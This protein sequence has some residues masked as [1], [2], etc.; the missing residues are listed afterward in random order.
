MSVVRGAARRRWL[1]AGAFVTVLCAT[2][3]AIAAYPARAANPGPDRLRRL[4]LAS[5]RVAHEGLAESRGSL[6][7]PALP[8]LEDAAALLGGTA[9]IRAWDDGRRSRV[10]L[11]SPTGERDHFRDGTGLAVWDYERDLLTRVAGEPVVR[12][13]R[14]GDLLPPAL[15]RRLLRQAG[16]GDR[17]TAVQSRRVA[18]RAVPGLRVTAT[19]PDTTIGAVEVWADPR[20]GLP[21]EVRLTARGAA[22]PALT[23]RFLDLRLRRPA[24]DAVAP[25]PA[26]GVPVA[27]VETPD[28]FS[29]LAARTLVPLPGRLAGRPAM[30]GTASVANVRGYA[31]GFASF[32]VVPLPGRY[33]ARLLDAARDAAAA[34]LAVRGGEAL[35]LRSPVLTA[36]LVS[37]PAHDQVYL[38][39]GAITAGL[40]TRVAGELIP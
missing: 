22:R 18:G 15:A 35:A 19:G 16:P 40:A 1:L 4:V 34:P 39:A 24:A 25:R 6:A 36:V 7:L 38:V 17:V 27:R 32:A 14:P 26:P 2:P 10:A 20:T 3:P 8:G 21:L 30:P 31:G 11:L 29:R 23:T 13:P 37:D 12:L 28:L 9:R 33:G 5:G